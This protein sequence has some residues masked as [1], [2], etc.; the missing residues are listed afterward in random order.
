MCVCVGVGVQL[1]WE[2]NLCSDL[3]VVHAKLVMRASLR[4]APLKQ[5]A[6]FA[7]A[8]RSKVPGGDRVHDTVTVVGRRLARTTRTHVGATCDYMLEYTRWR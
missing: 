3:V 8:G 5:R 1:L 4:P 2:C 6:A 7:I